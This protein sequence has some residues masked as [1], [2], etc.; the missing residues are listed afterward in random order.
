MGYDCE[1]DSE[2]SRENKLNISRM[3]NNATKI[4]HLDGVYQIYNKHLP[5]DGEVIR[6]EDQ[7]SFKKKDSSI[8][9]SNFRERL[10]PKSIEE[11][12]C[13]IYASIL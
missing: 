9:L 1:I 6:V 11:I 3:F 7:R 4:K 13:K 2:G 5:F 10:K 12:L 8:S